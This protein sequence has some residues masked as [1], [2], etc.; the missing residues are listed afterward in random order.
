MGEA[1]ARAL[2]DDVHRVLDD[3]VAGV[4]TAPIARDCRCVGGRLGAA[5]IPTET[6]PVGRHAGT[7]H[8][9]GVGC[10]EGSQGLL[11]GTRTAAREVDQEPVW[12][13]RSPHPDVAGQVLA[14]R[15]PDDGGGDL[16]VFADAFGGWRDRNNITHM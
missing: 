1:M 8:V 7:T 2:V 12:S 10:Q 15:R 16:P 9:H 13:K 6:G 3:G 5:L 11:A 4:E 14:K